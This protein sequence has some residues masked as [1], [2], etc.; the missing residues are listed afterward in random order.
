MLFT[1][2]D[3]FLDGCYGFL[4]GWTMTRR[5]RLFDPGYK[6]PRYPNELRHVLCLYLLRGWY[7]MKQFRPQLCCTSDLT[8]NS[9]AEPFLSVVSGVC[10]VNVTH[11]YNEQGRTVH[12]FYFRPYTQY[13]VT[14]QYIWLYL[15]RLIYATQR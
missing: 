10:F 4:V 13:I 11:T 6:D 2:I 14:I 3:T 5:V 9:K 1:F 8:V 7:T 15:S 12:I